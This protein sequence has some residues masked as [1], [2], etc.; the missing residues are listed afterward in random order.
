MKNLF[1]AI[2]IILLTFSSLSAQEYE[3]G[4]YTGI[5]FKAGGV[6]VEYLKIPITL[7]VKEDIIYVSCELLVYN[8]EYA[9]KPTGEIDILSNNAILIWGEGIGIDKLEGTYPTLT[10]GHT[11]EYD[12]VTYYLGGMDTGYTKLTWMELIKQ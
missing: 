5:V 9:M 6:D 2:G 3:T 12:G 1:I 8:N 11:W 4:T 10:H 7:V